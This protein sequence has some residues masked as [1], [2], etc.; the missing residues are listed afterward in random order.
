MNAR[1][2]AELIVVINAHASEL[3]AKDLASW[4]TDV[5]TELR[6]SSQRMIFL[7]ER[8]ALASRRAL[9]RGA[10]LVQLNEHLAIVTRVW[11]FRDADDQPV[12]TI[13]GP[14]TAP[15][16]E[17]F[18][19]STWN[20]GLV[21]A[22]DVALLSHVPALI[23]DIP[24]QPRSSR[25]RGRLP[26]HPTD[27]LAWTVLDA[28]CPRAAWVPG[29]TDDSFDTSLTIHRVGPGEIVDVAIPGGTAPGERL[30]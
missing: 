22:E 29:S 8:I 30:R 7:D 10:G 13:V 4:V 24:L 28:T 16:S 14:V 20:H 1:S 6:R 15:R 3:R 25:S 12:L 19:G 17:R 27:Q 2:S 23:V 5:S 26:A 18:L 11:T 21:S 9:P